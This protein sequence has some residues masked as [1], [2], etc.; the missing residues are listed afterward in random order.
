[1]SKKVIKNRPFIF[2]RLEV[3][4]VEEFGVFNVGDTFC[5]ICVDNKSGI[6]IGY[7]NRGNMVKSQK[8]DNNLFIFNDMRMTK[9]IEEYLKLTKKN[10]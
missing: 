4:F 7:D 5:S 1:M 6:M 3:K 10:K 8:F 9:E 2:E